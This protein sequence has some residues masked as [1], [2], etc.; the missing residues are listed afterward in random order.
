MTGCACGARRRPSQLSATTC[1][2]QPVWP[3][4]SS[5][6]TEPAKSAG[7]HEGREGEARAERR[8]RRARQS[9]W[10]CGGCSCRGFLVARASFWLTCGSV[11]G[12]RWGGWRWRAS[13]RRG[14]SHRRLSPELPTQAPRALQPP[15]GPHARTS[16][17]RARPFLSVTVRSSV[18]AFFSC[19]GR[20]PALG[21]RAGAGWAGGWAGGGSGARARCWRAATRSE[22]RAVGTLLPKLPRRPGAR[23]QTG[24]GAVHP[25][26]INQSEQ[27]TH[28]LPTKQGGASNSGKFDRDRLERA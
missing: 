14:G 18:A 26:A 23:H 2:S 10:C 22:P 27:A 16:R 20:L 3:W 11:G 17:S 9:P 15:P 24:V 4:E 21:C 25:L 6:Y 8:Y 5:Q 19:T 7:L 13:R 28:T 1:D 12:R